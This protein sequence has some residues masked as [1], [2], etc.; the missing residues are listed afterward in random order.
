[1]LG[2]MQALQA[3]KVVLNIGEEL[4]GSILMIDALDLTFNRV[5]IGKDV[6]CPA[7]QNDI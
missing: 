3:I 7:C 1:M 2:S 4:V 6:N 5:K